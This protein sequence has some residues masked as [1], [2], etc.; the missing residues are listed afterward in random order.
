MKQ[1]RKV[2]PGEIPL[3]EVRVTSFV[4]LY[5]G[6]SVES[7]RIVAISADPATVATVADELLEEERPPPQ[8]SGADPVRDLL[9]GR[10]REALELVREE[11]EA[12]SPGADD[13]ER[14]P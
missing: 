13:Q 3:E 12:G 9:T 5:R 7:A 14:E 10:R 4:V 1:G 2:A 8:A 6:A 11:A